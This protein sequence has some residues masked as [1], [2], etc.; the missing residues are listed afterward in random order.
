VPLVFL[1]GIHGAGKGVLGAHLVSECGG[2]HLSAGDV[3][4]EERAVQAQSK[5]VEDVKGNQELLIAGLE[6]RAIPGQSMV[7]DG[8]FAVLGASGEPHRIPL[9]VFRRL[10]PIGAIFLRIDPCQ[11]RT[12]LME[13]DGQAPTA[14][15]LNRLQTVAQDYA[16]EVVEDLGV[17]LLILPWSLP[18]LA[19]AFLRQLVSGVS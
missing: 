10:D 8:H 9:D 13:R 1:G 3:I 11:S 5:R 4:R 17:P 15:E 6:A 2:V 19:S 16:V 12:R 18:A 14:V 7:L